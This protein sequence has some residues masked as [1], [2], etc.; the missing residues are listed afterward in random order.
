MLNQY[1]KSGLKSLSK[2][3]LVAAGVVI[4]V[5]SMAGR[6]SAATLFSPFTMDPNAINSADSTT[7]VVGG[8][9]TG[10]YHEVL[11]ITGANTFH[12]V[13]YAQLSSVIDP[14]GNT[15][16]AGT[17]GDG[18]FYFLYA[19]FTSDGTFSLDG[20]G[21]VTFVGTSGGATIAN[22][23]GFNDTYDPTTGLVT[24]TGGDQTLA[25]AN[26]VPIV[27]TGIGAPG[28]NQ[29]SYSFVFAP[30]NL[31][32][33]LGT[34]FFTSPVPFYM[35]AGVTGQFATFSLTGSSQLHGSADVIFNPVPEPATLFMFGLGLLGLGWEY[36]RRTANA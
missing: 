28:L 18:V 1:G 36:R 8:D 25:T 20:S 21:N 10:E 30:V 6:A 27:S 24:G 22:D 5:G 3:L 13:A 33:P 23:V 26:L 17:S 9:L 14:S 31:T 15:V 19:T 16:P 35:S 2:K 11:S 34:S 29:G 4:A 7:S 32:S 12:A